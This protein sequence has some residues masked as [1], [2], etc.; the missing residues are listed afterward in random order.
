[1]KIRSGFVSNS[2]SASYI[3][4]VQ[5]KWEDLT[6]ELMHEFQFTNDFTYDGLVERLT[7]R[8]EKYRTDIFMSENKGG[9]INNMLDTYTRERLDNDIE[10]LE[11]VNKYK[12]KPSEYLKIALKY[13]G[14][15][16]AQNKDDT[17]TFS[18]FT[19]MH[20]SYEDGPNDIFK[21]LSLYFMYE[22]KEH[23]PKFTVEHNG[24]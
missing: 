19:S 24:G 4:N 21:Q 13:N 11:K 18:Y 12:D 16:I 17:I 7:K 20:N 1:M 14:I 15:E 2:S 22:G 9:S 10:I 5:A 8:I 6:R 23:N 3:I